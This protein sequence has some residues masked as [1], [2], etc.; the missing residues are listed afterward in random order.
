MSDLH[1]RNWTTG[2]SN[3]GIVLYKDNNPR[4]KKIVFYGNMIL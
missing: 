1:T 3:E 2:M 4:E